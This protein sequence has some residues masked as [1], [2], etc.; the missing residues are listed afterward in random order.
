[1]VYRTIF[2]FKVLHSLLLQRI[3]IRNI[4]ILSDNQLLFFKFICVLEILYFNVFVRCWTPQNCTF[5]GSIVSIYHPHTNNTR[6][7]ITNVFWI[8][9]CQL[10]LFRHSVLQ[11]LL[12]WHPFLN[13]VLFPFFALSIRIRQRRLRWI[14]RQAQR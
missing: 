10:K 2:Y 11:L 5:N 6:F 8:R 13:D 9:V 4:I 1:M 14:P 12:L 7:S 3:R